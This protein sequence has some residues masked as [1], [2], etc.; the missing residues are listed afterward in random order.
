MIFSYFKG[1]TTF[2]SMYSLLTTLGKS[3]VQFHLSWAEVNQGLKFE[4]KYG[5]SLEILVHKI[6][7]FLL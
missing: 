4:K 1:V 5:S 6:R 2:N 7:K 3:A